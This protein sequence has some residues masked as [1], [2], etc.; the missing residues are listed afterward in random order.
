LLP[1]NNNRI[2]YLLDE[3]E[4]QLFAVLDGR[5]THLRPL[6]TLAIGTGMRRG[7]QL[8]SALGED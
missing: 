1:E 6:V 7:D 3:E 2:R 8:K 5:R 4:P